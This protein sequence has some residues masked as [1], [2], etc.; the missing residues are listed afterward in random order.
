MHMIQLLLRCALIQCAECT[1]QWRGYFPPTKSVENLLAYFFHSIERNG[2]DAIVSRHCVIFTHQRNALPR[3]T[4]INDFEC[5]FF[6]FCS[7]ASPQTD[8]VCVL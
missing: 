8:C 3:K 2:L 6:F 4:N 7:V 5:C 1:K